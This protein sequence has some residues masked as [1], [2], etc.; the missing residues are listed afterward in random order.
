MRGGGIELGVVEGRVPGKDL[1]HASPKPDPGRSDS[2]PQA[3]ELAYSGDN[4][5]FNYL[6][7]P[8]LAGYEGNPPHRRS[9]PQAPAMMVAAAPQDLP[10]IDTVP[11]PA[12]QQ[13]ELMAPPAVQAE[14]VGGKSYI[15][16]EGVDMDAALGFGNAPQ[17]AAPTALPR[18][19]RLM[20]AEGDSAQPV[21]DGIGM[22]EPPVLVKPNRP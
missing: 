18:G 13:Q 1:R 3:R 19:G 22:D 14:H 15:P 11:P 8:N 16:P 4:S 2:E 7:T 10:M 21:V 9:E 5:A 6:D 12:G 20:I 17:A